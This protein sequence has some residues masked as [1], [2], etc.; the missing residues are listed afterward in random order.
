MK[1]NQLSEII[2]AAATITTSVRGAASADRT[3]PS[4]PC[5]ASSPAKKISDQI[6]R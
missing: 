2:T 1:P 3:C 4:R 5:T 6:V